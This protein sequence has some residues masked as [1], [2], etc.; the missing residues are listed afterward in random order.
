M[1]W[2]YLVKDLAALDED[3]LNA[4]GEQGWELIS[5]ALSGYPARAV[6]KRLKGGKRG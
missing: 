6:F 2:E 1:K 5:A 3:A 4:L